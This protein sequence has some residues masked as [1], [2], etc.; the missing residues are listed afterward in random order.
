MTKPWASLALAITVAAGCGGDGRSTTN[1]GLRPVRNCE[2][3]E[4]APCDVR[5]AACHQRLFE[6][7]TCLRGDQPGELPP[8]AVVTEAD[9]GA[10]LA[11]EAA[12][13]PQP[14][15]LAAWDWAWS[16]LALT[17]PGALA[18][19]ERTAE[20]TKLVG[21]FY[22][23]DTKAITVVDHG[24][25]FDD[26]TASPVL[27]HEL[28]HALQDREVDLAK[29]NEGIVWTQ[30]ASL[31]AKAVIEGEAR[32]QE[33]RYRAA[34]AGYDVDDADLMRHFDNAVTRGQ[35]RLL[36]EASP[37]TSSQLRF[38]Y[39]WG[40]RYVYDTWQRGGMD[41]VHARLLAP[42]TTTRVLMASA[43]MALAPE[44]SPA[45]PA[46]PMVSG[47]WS[48]AGSNMMGAWALFLT[49]AMNAP[50]Q[51]AQAEA[52]ALTWRTDS[53]WYYE[54]AAP[55]TGTGFAWRI[56]LA[57]EESAAR[58]AMFAAGLGKY[59]VRSS[60]TTVVIMKTSDGA[61]LDLVF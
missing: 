32:M 37:L 55:A 9:F 11:E 18:P 1:E 16:T 10:M 56:E 53:L 43:D 49:L 24:E 28:V 38:P 60:G 31:A 5:A 15:H 33:T 35:E 34:L 4:H 39:E 48:D 22:R 29:V 58:L 27:L 46:T 41:A 40:A 26:A 52:I 50:A 6:L 23:F 47:E 12:M 19:A 59:D 30:D 3:L 17:A 13:R 42:P 2:H 21:G 36:M 61:S 20:S 51:V 57:T 7:A 8:I 45:P 14:A 25:A 54:R 44:P